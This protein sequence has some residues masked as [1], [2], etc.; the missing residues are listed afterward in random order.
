MVEPEVERLLRAGKA[1]IKLYNTKKSN[2]ALA[3]TALFLATG[4]FVGGAKE[5]KE[6]IDTT[7]FLEDH[8]LIIE[9][10]RKEIKFKDIK[11]I[12]MEIVNDIVGIEIDIG[13]KENILFVSYELALP[14]VIELLMKYSDYV[15]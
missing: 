4:V 13:K 11:K 10:P 12:D 2:T 7:L 3:S 9:K 14:R 6:I 8:S 5:E 1:K 15:K